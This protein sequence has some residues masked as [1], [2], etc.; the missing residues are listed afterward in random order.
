MIERKTKKRGE[1]TEK[2]GERR[3]RLQTTK[4]AVSI[5]YLGSD[6]EVSWTCQI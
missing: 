2:R 1:D 3:V 4:I 6:S 5:S